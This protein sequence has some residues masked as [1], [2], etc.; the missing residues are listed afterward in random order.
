M[1]VQ[2]ANENI[3]VIN[4]TAGQEFQEGT[5]DPA[6]DTINIYEFS[7]EDKLTRVLAHE[8]GHAIGLDH[9]GNPSSIMYAL[10]KSNSLKL[11]AEDIAALKTLCKI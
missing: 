11:S 7:T 2:N 3:D 4:Q 1:L 6:T 8:L 5:Y 10:N 9:N